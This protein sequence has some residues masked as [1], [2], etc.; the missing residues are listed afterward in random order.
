MRTVRPGLRGKKRGSKADTVAVFA[1]VQDSD[2]DKG[3]AGVSFVTSFI[4][5]SS[6]GNEHRYIFLPPDLSPDEADAFGQSLKAATGGDSD[7]GVITQPYR[8]AGTPNYP[9]ATKRER[10]RVVTPTHVTKA[11]GPIWTREQL[12]AAFP[13]ATP[14]EHSHIPTGLTGIVDPHVEELV[15]E[16]GDHRSLQVFIAC[17]A[18]HAAGMTPDDL[19]DLMRQY[20]D[21]CA[22][23]FL[24]P[25]RLRKEI[26]RAWKK[27]GPRRE[28][29]AVASTY[30]DNARTSK[31][32]ARAELEQRI[33]RFLDAPPP[34]AFERYGGVTRR[35]HAVQSPVSPIFCVAY[36]I[37]KDART[38]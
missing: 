32:A 15:A 30:P 19:E 18:A 36:Y 12:I 27:I 14:Q 10:G 35:V 25:D 4:V 16:C 31:E 26:N 7:T 29:A 9:N 37:K 23:K 22:S 6:P 17:V 5:E 20:P 1:L 24:K 2:A 21:G 38:P 34:N 33:E 3:A 28:R 13:P 8:V 11:D